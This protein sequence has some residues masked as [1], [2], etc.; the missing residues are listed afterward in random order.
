LFPAKLVFK[1]MSYIDAIK[2]KIGA[3]QVF[4]TAI[5]NKLNPFIISISR[6]SCSTR[7]ANWAILYFNNTS[8]NDS[9]VYPS[10]STHVLE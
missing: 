1:G 8:F 10:G 3:M 2:I 6:L 9:S 4:V 7:L 5:D